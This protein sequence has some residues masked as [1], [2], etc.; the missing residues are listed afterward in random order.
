MLTWTAGWT[1]LA[2]NGHIDETVR[3]LPR[4]VGYAQPPQLFL[5][6]GPGR[7]RDGARGGG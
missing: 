3:N 7:F 5:N 6:E 4:N 2:V 1:L